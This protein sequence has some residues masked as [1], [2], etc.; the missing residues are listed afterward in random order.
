MLGRE[1]KRR[2][3]I[4]LAREEYVDDKDDKSKDKDNDGIILY[5]SYI[6]KIIYINERTRTRTTV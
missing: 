3:F 1:V 5:N 4:I 6:F 2:K